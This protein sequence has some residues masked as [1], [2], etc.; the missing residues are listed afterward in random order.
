VSVDN[1]PTVTLCQPPQLSRGGGV[2]GT[3]GGDGDE[4]PP[5]AL[6]RSYQRTWQRLWV[7]GIN[8]TRLEGILP[9]DCAADE[10]GNA[11]RRYAARPRLRRAIQTSRGRPRRCESST[12][13]HGLTMLLW[14]PS[15]RS[16]RQWTWNSGWRVVAIPGIF[17]LV[18][19]GGDG[20][21]WRRRRP[22][23]S[24]TRG[25]EGGVAIRHR[26]VGQ[27]GRDN[28]EPT[29]DGTARFSLFSYGAGVSWSWPRLATTMRRR[30]YHDMKLPPDHPASCPRDPQL[31]SA[32]V[33]WWRIPPLDQFF[34]VVLN[35]C[36]SMGPQKS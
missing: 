28:D 24:S 8:T 5:P 23:R 30:R 33:W 10:V 7:R 27:R 11:T 12:H 20:R 26:T 9:A 13:P 16:N 19:N 22:A 21:R 3:R 6:R 18:L 34:T 35:F 4:L 1:D 31:A 32:M 17:T 36:G 14:A 29:G 15:Q 25:E 2:P